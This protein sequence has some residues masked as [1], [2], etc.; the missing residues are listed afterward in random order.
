M[1]ALRRL[2][3][4]FFL[5]VLS[6]GSAH[7]QS[8]A[9]VPPP[10]FA[11]F[12]FADNKPVRTFVTDPET[13]LI[14][15]DIAAGRRK[16]G[17]PNGMILD[18]RPGKSPYDPGWSWHFRP[19]TVKMAEVTIEVCDATPTYIEEHMEEWF[20]GEKEAR[21]CGWSARLIKLEPLK[22]GD[23][24]FDG[25]VTVADAVAVLRWAVAP[26]P[27]NEA[28]V[29]AGDVAPLSPTGGRPGDGVL[30]VGDAILILRRALGLEDF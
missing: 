27:L 20:R 3:L 16:D 24:D 22:Y 26:A 18:D 4:L 21:W 9:A 13:V 5:V 12:T 29:I 7:A 2:S 8:P 28:E 1:H 10:L 6:A 19:E 11:T 23:V 30:N 14:L 25:N 15:L 17:I